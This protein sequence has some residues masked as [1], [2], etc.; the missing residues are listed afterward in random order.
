M[1]KDFR[2]A[3]VRAGILIG[4]G[5]SG[6][7]GPGLMIYSSSIA[8]NHEGGRSDTAMLSKV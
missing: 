7:S 3:Q 4:T 5:S 1:A 6:G 2:A 8:S